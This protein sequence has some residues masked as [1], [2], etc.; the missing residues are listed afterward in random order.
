MPAKLAQMAGTGFQCHR[1]PERFIQADKPAHTAQVVSRVASTIIISILSSSFLA[2]QQWH[3]RGHHSIVAG[4][5]VARQRRLGRLVEGALQDYTGVVAWYRVKQTGV[6]KAY[7][8][9]DASTPL[10]LSHLYASE[11]NAKRAAERALTRLR[12]TPVG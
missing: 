9:G 4:I 12:D 1:L 11:G 5:S 6:Q 7:T 3:R 10:R 8:A 2:K